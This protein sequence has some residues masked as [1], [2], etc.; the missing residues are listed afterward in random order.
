MVACMGAVETVQRHIGDVNKPCP[1]AENAEPVIVYYVYLGNI[2][3]AIVSF[4]MLF[5]LVPSCR[6]R[7]VH[8]YL[9]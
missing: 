2:S 5:L 9:Q 1:G 3:L 6:G 7:E 4:A 8:R